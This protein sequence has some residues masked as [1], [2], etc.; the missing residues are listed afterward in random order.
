M[1]RCAIVVGAFEVGNEQGR[2]V[3]TGEDA[4]KRRED[5]C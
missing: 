5:N 4:A 2:L 3:Q 1:A